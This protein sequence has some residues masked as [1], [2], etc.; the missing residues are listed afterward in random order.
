MRT[1]CLAGAV[2]SI[3]ALLFQVRRIY[4]TRRRT[5]NANYAHQRILLLPV[6]CDVYVP[7]NR[8]WFC[9]SLF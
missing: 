1:F 8:F 6:V 2:V 3:T 9:V 4:I 7:T 5:Q